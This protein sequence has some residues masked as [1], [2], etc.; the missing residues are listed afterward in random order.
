[1]KNE[2]KQIPVNWAEL[3]WDVNIPT[4]A[5]A[6]NRLTSSADQKA[7]LGPWAQFRPNPRLS[8][9]LT[10]HPGPLPFEGRGRT[11]SRAFTIIELLVVIAIIAA[12]AALIFPALGRAQQKAKITRTKTEMKNLEAAIKGYE[13]EY[14]RFPGSSAPTG[15]SEGAGNPDFTYGTAGF[16][17]P[18]P[19][20]G[21]PGYAM[22]NSEVIQILLDLP[23]GANSQNA[24]NPRH[25]NFFQAKMVSTG[26]G[27]STVDDVFR[28]PWGNPYIITMDMNGDEYCADALYGFLPNDP[29]KGYDRQLASVGLTITATNN[30]LKANVQIWSLGPD[31]L[32]DK[33][34]GAKEGVNADNVLGW[35]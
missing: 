24:R 4:F 32:A 11:R 12:L 22:N 9:F 23:K 17:P 21:T 35:Q 29:A 13:T 3:S 6:D 20:I 15:G 5:A 33:T 28:D 2:P 8:R 19:P 14:S 1:M 27:V 10:P 25:H 31:G 30:V 16:T 18:L 7:A 26:P 34:I